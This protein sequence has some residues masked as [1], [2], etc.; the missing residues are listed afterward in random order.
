MVNIVIFGET[1][2]GKSSVINL[3]AGQQVARTSP[4]SHRCTLEWEEYTVTVNNGTRYQVFDTVGLEEPRLN[5]GDYLT[6]ITNAD[7]LIKALN[8]RGGIHLLLFCIRGGRVTATMQSN[9]RLFFEFLCQEKVPLVLVV[10]N[11]ENE[12][13]RMEDWYTRNVGHLEKH[14]ICSVGHACIT[15]AITID[16]RHRAKY[17]ESQRTVRSVVQAHCNTL[18]EGWTGGQGWFTSL[19]SRLMDFVTG[20]PKKTDVI[21]VL[22]RRCGMTKA[23][24]HQV[25]QQIRGAGETPY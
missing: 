20:R 22:T 13:E 4:D 19:L 17:E 9:Y 3:M 12:K 18:A 8:E 10:T 15:A 23:A 21:G 14:N 2:A 11:L 5:S 6:A 16:D 1:G 24:A 7:S 25:L